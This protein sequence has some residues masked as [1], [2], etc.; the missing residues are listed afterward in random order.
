MPAKGMNKL[1][2]ETRVQIIS[3]LFA[4]AAPEAAGDVWTWAAIDADSKLIASW[5]VGD[6]STYTGTSFM[7]DLKT[8]LCQPRP[9]HHGKQV[10]RSLATISALRSTWPESAF[11]RRSRP[12]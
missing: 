12:W 11:A 4:K 8:R 3:M 5:Y 6:R 1:P 2:L 9:A 7:G 10:I